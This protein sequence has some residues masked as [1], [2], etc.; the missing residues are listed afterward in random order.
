MLMY[1]VKRQGRYYGD[2]DSTSRFCIHL[3]TAFTACQRLN[4]CSMTL[5][6]LS[7]CL[8]PSCCEL[9]MRHVKRSLSCRLAE[10]L[11]AQ[12]PRPEHRHY[13]TVVL[14]SFISGYP[15]HSRVISGIRVAVNSLTEELPTNET[16]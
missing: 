13:S 15:H 11:L 10:A 7:G 12:L 9:S 6:T 14:N 3:M 1:K 8:K 4:L 2:A 16:L 5:S